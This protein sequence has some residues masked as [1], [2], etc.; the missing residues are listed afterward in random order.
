[1]K[2][3]IEK[4]DS[5]LPSIICN[6]LI[7]IAKENPDLSTP[8]STVA[9]RHLGLEET[10]KVKKTLDWD[11][12][13]KIDFKT[14]ILIRN[15]LLKCLPKY[16]KENIYAH[17]NHPDFVSVIKEKEVELDDFTLLR[18]CI[19][20]QYIMD[21]RQL[22]LKKYTDNDYFHWH[23]DNGGFGSIT[24]SNR[25]LVCMFYLNDVKKGGT[26]DFLHQNVSLKPTKGSL[27]I[28]P[29]NWMYIHRGT[30]PIDSEKWIMNFWLIKRNHFTMRDLLLHKSRNKDFLNIEN[31]LKKNNDYLIS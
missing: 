23:T 14:K 19:F 6:R 12:K 29:A 26:T 28:F 9:T 4:Y 21:Q 18:K 24:S 13:D 15:A 11:I 30:P 3:F 8:G 27:V 17:Q 1:M 31:Y 20:S 25:A 2:N 10:Q 22:F 5:V 7:R 16:F